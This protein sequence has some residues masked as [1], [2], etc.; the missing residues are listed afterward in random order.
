MDKQAKHVQPRPRLGRGLSSLIAN[1]A[2]LSADDDRTYQHVTG[3]P[4]VKAAPRA[5][6]VGQPR[7]IP[8]D[9]IAPNPFQPRRQFNPDELAELTES[10][11]RQGVVQP[12][13]VA[14]GQEG[15]ERPYVM[16]AGERRLRAARQAG[17]TTVPCV[18]RQATGQQMLEWALIEN[19]QRADLNPLERAQAYRDY[20]DRFNLTQSEAAE[21]LGQPRAT[22]AN[23]LRV[24]DLGDETQ[25][26][27][28]E[29]ALTFG[30]AKLLAGL[31]DPARQLRLS[32]K[33]VKGCLSVRQLESLIAEGA[34]PEAA[35]R[36]PRAKA[37]YIADLEQRLT[38]AVGSRVTIHPGRAKHSG[39]IVIEYYSLDDFDRIAGALGLRTEET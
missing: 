21:R 36:V 1:S 23:Y 18:I 37:P 16:I 14:K 28:I 26:M 11:V 4:P 2:E 9:D 6:P 15:A 33:V 8:L 38:Q 27:L 30:H 32:R 20:M 39:R 5:A 19:I 7:E 12:L 10:I 22:V 34:S 35:P 3:L 13:I 24:L 29:G 17:L 31:A 25:R